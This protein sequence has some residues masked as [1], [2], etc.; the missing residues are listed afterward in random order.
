MERLE[1]TARFRPVSRHER[2]VFLGRATSERLDHVAYGNDATAH[3]DPGPFA[4]RK[5]VLRRPKPFSPCVSL[6]NAQP[7]PRRPIGGGPLLQ[8]GIKCLSLTSSV[9]PG[10]H[11]EST[12]VVDR[13][14]RRSVMT[15][16]IATSEPSP[17]V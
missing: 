5:I 16:A 14:A 13:T 1:D 11:D 6:D 12:D 2:E 9:K 7:Q 3:F 8:P 15:F 17:A 4:H 10:G